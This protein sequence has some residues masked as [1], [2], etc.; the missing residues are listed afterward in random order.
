MPA[1][2]FIDQRW[3]MIQS[4]TKR[5]SNQ[6]RRN[7]REHPR[8]SAHD[9]VQV[10]ANASA[11]GGNAWCFPNRRLRRLK[12]QQAETGARRKREEVLQELRRVV[13]TR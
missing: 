9:L 6:G 5:E 11:S 10:S 7:S 12:L 13:G 2:L 4:K 8:R 3:E 1:K